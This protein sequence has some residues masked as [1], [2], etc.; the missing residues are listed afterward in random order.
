MFKR[1]C[2]NCKKSLN[3]ELRRKLLKQEVVICPWCTK[4]LRFNFKYQI[5]NGCVYGAV[6][7]VFCI[8][9]FDLAAFDVALI[10][11]VSGAFLQKYLDILFPLEINRS[12]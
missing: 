10:A 9:F 7:G 3:W 1:Y 6:I 4:G 11:I 2:P 8:T 5:V 12:L